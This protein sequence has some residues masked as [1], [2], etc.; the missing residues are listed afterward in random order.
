MERVNLCHGVLRCE[1]RSAIPGPTITVIPRWE[2]STFSSPLVG[3]ALRPG[4]IADG[5]PPPR[6]KMDEKTSI[7][8]VT[9]PTPSLCELQAHSVHAFAG[10]ARWRR[11]PHSQTMV[12]EEPGWMRMK[13]SRNLTSR[14]STV[15]MPRRPL[16]R[17]QVTRTGAISA[18]RTI[19]APLAS[20]VSLGGRI[21]QKNSLPSTPPSSAEKSV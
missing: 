15:A 19:T 21:C 10:R 11:S 2:E 9:C 18:T 8:G 12:T 20:G 4:D 6:E 5:Q 7:V 14:Y 17:T 1:T 3:I 16:Q 13:R